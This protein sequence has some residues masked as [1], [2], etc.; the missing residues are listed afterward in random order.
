M[1]NQPILKNEIAS[2]EWFDRII[3]TIMPDG[4]KYLR[5]S[6]IILIGNG[7]DLVHGLRTSYSDTINNF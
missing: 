4:K 1:N 6:R 7:F 3:I 5:V 2:N